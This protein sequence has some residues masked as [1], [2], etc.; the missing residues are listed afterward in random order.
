MWPQQSLDP[1]LQ[2]LDVLNNLVRRRRCGIP[3]A[4]RVVCIHH[5]AA[6]FEASLEYVA[7][8]LAQNRH[9]LKVLRV[10]VVP[11]PLNHA[12]KNNILKCTLPWGS[13][14]VV[15]AG[16]FPVAFVFLIIVV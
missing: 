4:G 13:E 6:L 15:D 5:I 3:T 1:I 16:R 10:D 7:I 8:G 9:L 14:T 12:E 2:G 11:M